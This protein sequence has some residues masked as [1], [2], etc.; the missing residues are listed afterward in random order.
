MRSAQHDHTK[1][2]GSRSHSARQC[3]S[4][5]TSVAQWESSNARMTGLRS[6]R[7]DPMLNSSKGPHAQCLTVQA[8]RQR[9]I[10]VR[11]GQGEHARLN[12][13]S[14]S[15]RSPHRDVASLC[16]RFHVS[17]LQ[18][19]LPS[20]PTRQRDPTTSNRVSTAHTNDTAR[21]ASGT[22]ALTPRAETWRVATRPAR[23]AAWPETQ[24]R[25]CQLARRGRR[26]RYPP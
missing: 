20:E 9:N 13:T 16:S 23:P 22:E 25:T 21:A 26:P 12:G 8:C 6:V 11:H 17:L 5:S 4:K 24:D 3:S 10:S 15:A 14:Q 7:P 19:I 18:R 2:T 1:S